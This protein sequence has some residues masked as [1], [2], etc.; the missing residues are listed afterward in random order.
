MKQADL[1]GPQCSGASRRA[2]CFCPGDKKATE[3]RMGLCSLGTLCL[4]ETVMLFQARSSTST[5]HSSP[6]RFDSEG[7]LTLRPE[8]PR[9]PVLEGSRRPKRESEVLDMET[10]WVPPA[11]GTGSPPGVPQPDSIHSALLHFP[12]AIP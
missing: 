8:S 6:S 5:P 11:C 3:V 9:F 1:R 10:H 2:V 4:K 12:L 7:E